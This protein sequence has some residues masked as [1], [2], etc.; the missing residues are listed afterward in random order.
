MLDKDDIQPED[1]FQVLESIHF[2]K[3]QPRNNV[4]AAKVQGFCL[5]TTGVYSAG[6]VVSNATLQRRRLT[7]FLVKYCEQNNPDFKFS[8]IQVNK[9]VKC[10]LHIDGNNLGPTLIIG[11]GDYEPIQSPTTICEYYG[12]HLWIQGRGPVDV[13]NKWENFDGNIPHGTIT[14]YA[15]T[16]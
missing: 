2:K 12:G 16:R 6:M 5:G 13:K 4:S 14:P 8:C 9:D 1:V 7:K 3:D 11:I 15:G 10:D